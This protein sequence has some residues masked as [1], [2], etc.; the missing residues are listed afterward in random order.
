V[1]RKLLISDNL[2]S[3]LSPS[4]IEQVAVKSQTWPASPDGL[5]EVWFILS[6]LKQARAVESIPHRSME[7]RMRMLSD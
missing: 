2:F 5:Q 4:V 6:S 7:K 3:H 1:G